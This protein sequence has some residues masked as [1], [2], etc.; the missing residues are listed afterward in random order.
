MDIPA[1]QKLSTA[2]DEIVDKSQGVF[3]W[4][5][6]VVKDL[7]QGVTNA[8]PVPMLRERLKTI[9]AELEVYFKQ[10]LDSVEVRYQFLMA[11]SFQSALA[12]TEPLRSH[13]GRP[14]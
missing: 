13:H 14:E 5:F 6:L 1:R 2:V 7:L 10:I 3:L 9:P 8:D 4:G 11:M 12:A